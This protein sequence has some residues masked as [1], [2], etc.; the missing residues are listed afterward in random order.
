MQW[1][2]VESEHLQQYVGPLFALT[3]GNPLVVL[4]LKPKTGVI[5]DLQGERERE[6]PHC[7]K[8]V[9]PIKYV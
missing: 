4:H 5:V 3:F 7:Q 2:K 9:D 1:L 8:V 6:N